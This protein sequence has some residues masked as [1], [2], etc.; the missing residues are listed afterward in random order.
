MA[1]RWTD[2]QFDAL[3]KHW[4]KSPRDLLLEATEHTFNSCAS[5]AFRESLPHRKADP[6][7]R[8]PVW[9]PAMDAVLFDGRR[10]GLRFR[11]IG[12]KLGLSKNAAIA[13]AHRLKDSRK[14]N[15][16]HSNRTAWGRPIDRSGAVP[17]PMLRI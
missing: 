7:H 5:K 14:A 10:D 6:R 17:M 3:W 1:K 11:E 16:T 12:A 4:E 15:V 13:R 2:E 8:P 9:T